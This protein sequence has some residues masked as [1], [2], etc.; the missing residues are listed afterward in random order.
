TGQQ[1]WQRKEEFKKIHRVEFCNEHTLLVQQS[2]GKGKAIEVADVGSGDIVAQVHGVRYD[3]HADSL[4][5]CIVLLRTIRS[6]RVL[7]IRRSLAEEPY[8]VRATSA[9][10]VLSAAFGD[11][12]VALTENETGL[13][14]MLDVESGE[15]RWTYQP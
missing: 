8:V 1:L 2:T 7:E 11:G 3:L 9:G 6:R 12:W 10:N 13:I 4:A 15:D 5:P 14:L